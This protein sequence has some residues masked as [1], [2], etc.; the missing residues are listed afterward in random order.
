MRLLITGSRTWDDPMPIEVVIERVAYRA[1]FDPQGLTVVHGGA[2]GADMWAMITVRTLRKDGTRISEECHPA[3]WGEYGRRAGMIRN[4][5]MVATG[6]DLA[7]AFLRDNSRGTTGCM[8]LIRRAN[9]P[10]IVVRWEDRYQDSL[11]PDLT[12]P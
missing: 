7:V 12:T 6:I 4:A 10:L 8:E 11:T 3:N 2:K 1:R 9:I 5:E